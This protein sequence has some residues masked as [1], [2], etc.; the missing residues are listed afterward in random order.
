MA[1][2]DVALVAFVV[3]AAIRGSWRGFYREAFGLLALVGGLGIAALAAPWVETVIRDAVRLPPPLPAAMAFV[4]VFVAAHT[5]FHAA[6]ALGEWLRSPT[7]SRWA[8]AL[9]GGLLGAGK[10]AVLLAFVLLFLHLFPIVPRVDAYLAES[11]LARQ[12]VGAAARFIEVSGTGGGAG[13]GS[14]RRA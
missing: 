1:T 13:P 4:G 11:P 9:G 8:S 7:G 2:P 3:L 6:G 10:G 5:V 14:E 12:L